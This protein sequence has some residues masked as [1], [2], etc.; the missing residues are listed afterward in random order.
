M[1]RPDYL[2]D[3]FA[4]NVSIIKR[5]TEGVSHEESLIQLPFRANSLNWILG[6]LVANRNNVLKLLEAE[7]LMDPASVERYAR[8][9]EPITP[10]SPDALPLE[11]L[12]TLL[13]E[14]QSEIA[15]RMEVLPEE[16]F[17]RQLAFFGT[18]EMTVGEWLLFFYFHDS[19]HTG[20][21]E[22]M[23]QAAGK[24]DKII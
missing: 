2:A 12:M 11:H 21:T 17:Q 3:S 1:I 5:Q 15:K 20:Q 13:E 10:D 4:R 23:R 18:T 6:H 9:S 19:Y 8:D 14:A 22:I 7:S 16:V 24:D